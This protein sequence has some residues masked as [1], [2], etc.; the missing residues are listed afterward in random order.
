MNLKRVFRAM[1]TVV[2]V[3]A[4]TV[5]F[6]SCKKDNKDDGGSLKVSPP[7]WIHGSW[8]LE[9]EELFKF[10]ADD[11]IWF[12]SSFKEDKDLASVTEPKKTDALY[13]IVLTPKKGDEIKFSFKKGDGKYIESYNELLDMWIQYDKLK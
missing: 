7:A 10:T 2:C 1:A 5:M 3:L 4:V 9:G 11:F 8:G 6:A 13:E 12:G